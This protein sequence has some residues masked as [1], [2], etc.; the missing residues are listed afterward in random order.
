MVSVKELPR[1][2]KELGMRFGKRE[3]NVVMVKPRPL[4]WWEE[5]GI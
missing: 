4:G 3:L 2:K 5:L 1:C